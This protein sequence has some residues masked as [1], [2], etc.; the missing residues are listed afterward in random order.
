MMDKYSFDKKTILKSVLQAICFSFTLCILFWMLFGVLP[1]WDGTGVVS[2]NE[3]V[4]AVWVSLAICV[5]MSIWGF[6]VYSHFFTKHLSLLARIIIFS[7]GGY[8]LITAWVFGSGWCPPE[9]FTLYS[10]VCAGALLFAA[11]IACAVAKSTDKKLN[12]HL[13]DYQKNQQDSLGHKQLIHGA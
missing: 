5:C 10:V 12:Q 7:V 6:A 1:N 3:V 2:I 11:L 13:E 4:H 9:G 8:A